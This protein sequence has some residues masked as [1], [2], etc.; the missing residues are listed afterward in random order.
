M[1]ERKHLIIFVIITGILLLFYSSEF[2]GAE[3][4]KQFDVQTRQKMEKLPDKA[5]EEQYTPVLAS[6]VAPS[7]PAALSDRQ[8]YLLYGLML[9][10]ASNVPFTIEKLEVM[11]IKGTLVLKQLDT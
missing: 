9:T 7:C 10:N 5:P 4:K 8:S 6:F 2:F 11:T 3:K 1:K